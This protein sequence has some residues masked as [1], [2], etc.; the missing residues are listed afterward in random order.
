MPKYLL[1]VC[2]IVVFIAGFYSPTPILDLHLQDTY[3]VIDY[4]HGALI[5]GVLILPQAIIYF[6]TE[7]FRQYPVLKYLHVLPI[8]LFVAIL[9]YYNQF[10]DQYPT[11]YIGASNADSLWTVSFLERVLV[12]SMIAIAIGHLLFIIN[13]II[14]FVR[15]KKPVAKHNNVP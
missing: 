9:F 11:R 3:Y 14:G 5:L 12:F 6:L 10:V 2:V 7:K 8:I 13:I 15:G 1:L 4:W